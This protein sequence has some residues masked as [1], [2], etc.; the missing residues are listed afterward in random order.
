MVGSRSRTR[1]A[2]LAAGVAVL[3]AMGVVAASGAAS[4]DSVVN[5]RT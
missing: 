1:L 3:A 4:A 2:L 5:L